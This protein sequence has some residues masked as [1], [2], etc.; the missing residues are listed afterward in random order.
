MTMPSVPNF[1]VTSNPA[2]CSLHALLDDH[3]I[4]LETLGSAL[5]ALEDTIDG[6]DPSAD[7]PLSRVQAVVVLLQQQVTRIRTQQRQL[8]DE[9][10]SHMR[11]ASQAAQ[12][13][14]A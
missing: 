9:G 3:S 11:S 2:A 10:R 14:C 13:V 1:T 4:Q 6:Y 8:S 7:E 12:E 5:W